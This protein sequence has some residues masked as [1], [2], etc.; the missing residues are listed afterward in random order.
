[1]T[2][3][4][5]AIYAYMSVQC[6]SGNSFWFW[7]TMI[8]GLFPIW[9]LITRKSND[10]VFDGLVFDVIHTVAFTLALLLITDEFHKLKTFQ[11]FGLLAIIIGLLMFR[12]GT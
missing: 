1:M 8:V 3:I 2:A 6:R 10:L 12:R 7:A 11:Y 4:F 9:P 5:Y